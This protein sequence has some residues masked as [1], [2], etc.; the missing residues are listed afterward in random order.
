M[1]LSASPLSILF[2]GLALLILEMACSAQ[3]MK[4]GIIAVAT[5]LIIA[6]DVAAGSPLLRYSY[7][8]YDPIGG[9]PV[10]MAWATNSWGA[11]GG[12][13]C[14]GGVVC[15]SREKQKS[16]LCELDRILCLWNSTCRNRSARVGHECG[17]GNLRCVCLRLYLECHAPQTSGGFAVF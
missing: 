2:L 16:P 9:V 5:A 11:F 7:L 13:R 4:V 3:V 10:F 8:G 1:L 15:C 17:W 14:A 6:A 12:L